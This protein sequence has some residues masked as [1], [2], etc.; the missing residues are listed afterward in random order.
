MLD[1]FR[2]F[3]KAEAI[4]YREKTWNYSEFISEMESRSAEFLARGIRP[5]DVVILKTNDYSMQAVASLWALWS[6]G[7]IVTPLAR[8]QWNQSLVCQESTDA[9]WICNCNEVSESIELE[10]IET[11]QQI[12]EEAKN[13]LE[14]VRKSAH[15]GL[16]LLTSGTT[17]LPRLALHDVSLLLARFQRKRESC[18]IL[19]FLMFDHLGGVDT[20]LHALSSGSLLVLPNP[21]DRSPE[22]IALFIEKFKIQLL[23][24]SPTFLNYLLISEMHEQH[25]LKSLEKIA[26]GTERMPQWLL[27]RL[28]AKLPWVRLTQSYGTTELGVPPVHTR[29]D[30]PGWIQLKL[31][32]SKI[33]IEDGELFLKTENRMIGYLNAPDPF[34]KEGWYATGDLIEFDA[35]GQFF[36]IVGR[37]SEMIN[38]GGEKVSPVAVEDVIRQAQNIKNVLVRGEP[39][40]L[41]GQMIVAEVELL[42]PEKPMELSSRLRTFCKNVLENHQIPSKFVIVEKLEQT[43]SGKLK[44]RTNI[45]S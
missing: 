11:R 28:Q 41:M 12:Q 19:A 26:F 6:L 39:N 13:K 31:D 10:F 1:R 34:D 35:S 14:I 23:A 16:I 2:S 22:S 15:P 21:G 24:T 7:A 5:G 32:P 20:M 40:P 18:R 42:E 8:N 3:G 30:D 17:R 36:R 27:N 29:N 25:S 38:V 33:K 37:R 4:V 43:S 44:R 45:N 9:R